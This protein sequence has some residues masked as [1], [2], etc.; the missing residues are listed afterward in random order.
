MKINS[1][2]TPSLVISAGDNDLSSVNGNK[3]DASWFS[4]ALQA[5][6]EK[7]APQDNQFW[8]NKLA[9]LTDRASDQS[10]QADKA[11]AKA[12]RSLDSRSVMDAN[13]TLSSYYL[14]SLLNA[15]LVGKGVQS[16]EKLTNLQ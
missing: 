12:S 13:R 6:E 5:P 2:D 4:A 15:K 8:I 10:S 3:A 7:S 1:G 16:L 9:D 11:L 14:E